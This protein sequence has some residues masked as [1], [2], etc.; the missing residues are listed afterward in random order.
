MS[1]FK[2]RRSFVCAFWAAALLLASV[3]DAATDEAPVILVLGDSISAAYGLSSAEGWVTLLQNRLRAQ[4]YGHRVVNAS[5]S[6][7]TTTGGLT[8]LPRA[9]ALHRPAIVVLELG[10][11]D[12]LRGLPLETSRANLA[13]MIELARA[14]GAQVLL[15]GMKMPP[16][17]GPKYTTGFE[18]I[19]AT[20]AKQNRLPFVPF[21][22]EKIALAPGMLQAD[23]LHPTAAAQPAMLDAVW[24][25][26]L[27]LLRRA[28]KG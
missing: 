11:N 23:G 6:G 2:A 13:R 18:T 5:V 14:A 9:L 10:G 28:G 8:R 16:N 17:Y 22:L 3:R 27:P 4:G 24:P 7:E 20:L 26:L 25:T 1:V 15:L 12:G 21:F 19:Y